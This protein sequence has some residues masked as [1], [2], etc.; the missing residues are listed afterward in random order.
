MQLLASLRDWLG[1]LRAQRVRTLTTLMGIAW[2]TFGVVGILAFGTGLADLMRERAQGLGSGVVILWGKRTTVPWAGRPSGRPIRLE[3]E[4]AV[5]LGLRV[6]TLEAV[7]PEFMRTERLRVG[8]R[9]L[10]V[11]ISGVFP[12]YGTLRKM[13]PAAG[14]RFLDD[15]DLGEARS[16]AFLGDAVARGLFGAL[17]PVGRT[18][19]LRGAPFTVVGVLAPK[20][21]DSDYEGTDDER[22]CIPS[23][24][25]R[26]V[27]G[28]RYALYLVYAARD[29]RRTAAA[30]AEVQRVLGARHGFDPADRDALGIW[31]TTESDRMRDTAFLAMDSLISLACL[32]TL[33]VGGIGVGNLMF[34]QVRRR[35]REIGLRLALGAQPRWI[36]Q[37]VLAQALLLVAAGGAAG[38][39]AAWLLG[40]LISI[41]PLT[42]VLGVPRISNAVGLAVVLVLAGIG[43]IA[44]W[45]PARRAAG[46]DPVRALVD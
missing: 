29:S 14:G 42:D 12:E 32:L 22:V 33:L 24:T 1:E 34:L 19:Q 36:L 20:L 26:R 25:F 46:L 3:E 23:S 44:G 13:R 37:E 31:D 40:F 8:A 16:V 15:R 11:R 30:T 35:T 28:D 17:D 27:F 6:P 39:A 2:G 38:F 45:F 9:I 41:S 21:Q 43:L 7:S 5:A 10:S 18:V 4:D